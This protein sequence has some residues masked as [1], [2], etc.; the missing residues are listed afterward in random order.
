VEEANGVVQ[1][2]E[3]FTILHEAGITHTADDIAKNEGFRRIFCV[4]Q[5]V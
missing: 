5:F 1:F 2:P 3:E 4:S